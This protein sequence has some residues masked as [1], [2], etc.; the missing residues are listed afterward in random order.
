MFEEHL[1]LL[2]QLR[3][4]D[5]GN[6]IF[7]AN[8]YTN[9]PLSA[10]QI[11]GFERRLGARLPDNFRA[12]LLEIGWG[13]GPYYGIWNPDDALE[14][15]RKDRDD[16]ER[17]RGVRADPAGRFPVTPA[18]LKA[19][20]DQILRRVRYIHSVDTRWPADGCLAFGPQGCNYRSALALTGRYAGTVWD[21]EVAFVDAGLFPAHRPL[22]L[23]NR[24]AFRPPKLHLLPR[25]PAFEVWY[26][27]WLEQCLADL[28]LRQQNRSGVRLSQ[29]QLRRCLAGIGPSEDGRE[30][31]RRR[32][33]PQGGIS[34]KKRDRESF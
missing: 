23:L 21:L 26:R 15:F 32:R 14:L 7:G 28:T 34:G 16:L 19:I 4:R 6:E 1:R 3:T 33:E 30:S 10:K 12:F 20:N 31:V 5:R 13:A 11:T 27:G 18:K 9:A 25:P 8:Q 2:T 29:Q 17:E 22:G 24:T